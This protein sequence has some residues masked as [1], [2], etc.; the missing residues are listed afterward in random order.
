ME[1]EMEYPADETDLASEQM[2]A[3]MADGEPVEL[4]APPGGLVGIFVEVSANSGGAASQESMISIGAQV[5]SFVE[6]DRELATA[7]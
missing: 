5:A 6:H 3:I 4:I 2:D 1:H 7:G